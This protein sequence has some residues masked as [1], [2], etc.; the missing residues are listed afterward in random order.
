MTG[1]TRRDSLVLGAAALGASSVPI[2]GA[3]AQNAAPSDVPTADVKPPDLPIEKGASLKL[4]RPAKFVDPDQ[5]WFDANTKKFTEATGVP[6]QVSYISWEDLGPQTAVIANTGAGADIVIGFSI[7][8]FL[9]TEKLVR[10]DDVAEYLGKKYGGWFDLAL[11]YG[12]KWKTNDWIAL[13]IG[14]GTGPTVYRVSWVKQAGYDSIPNDLDGFMT[15]CQKLKQIGHPC[16]FSLG[17]ALGDANGFAEWA[18]WTHGGSVVD[19]AGKVMLDSKPTIDALKYVAEL[20]KYM[21]PGTIAWNDSGNN[22]AYAAGDIGLT[23]NGV[24]IYFVLKNSK[25]PQLQQMAADTMHQKVPQGL[26]KRSPMS[27]AILN[28]MLFK[29]SKY[30]NAAKEYLRFMME[31]PQYGPWLS[32]CL[33]YWSEPLKSY[34]KMNFWTQDPKLGPYASAMDTIYYDGYAGPITPAASAVVAN[35]TVVDMF[36]SVAT[37]NSTPEAA[38]KQAARQ[39]ERY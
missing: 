21:I 38:A 22:K 33:G 16:G 3:R 26:A 27:A 37:G 6:V 7:A 8:P 14:G 36:A 30:P 28:A 35:Y 1:I 24:S 4:V 5:T 13:P 12:R 19:E 2:I 17:H 39:A 9:Y 11:L 25:D 32:N 29:H 10:M 15:L 18:L 23:F 34:A 20:Y 31:A